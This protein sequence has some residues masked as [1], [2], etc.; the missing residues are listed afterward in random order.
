M[1]TKKVQTPL[2]PCAQDRRLDCRASRPRGSR[3]WR[4]GGTGTAV[5]AVAALLISTAAWLAL[6][7][8]GTT[9]RCWHR[10]THFE[11]SPRSVSWRSHYSSDLRYPASSPPPPPSPPPPARR[12]GSLSGTKPIAEQLMLSHILF[13][14]AGSSRLWERRKEYVRLW[15]RPEEMRGHVWLDEQVSHDDD[16][17][18]P[19]MVSEDISRFRYT[20]PTGHPSGLRIARVVVES[21]RLGL[22]DVRW[23]VLGDDDTIFNVDNLVAVLSKYDWSEMVYIGAPSES[24]SANTYFSHNMAFGGGGIAISYALADAL[25]K[26]QD[27]CLERYPKLYGSDDRL[28]ACISE[29]GVPLTRESG[30][31]Q[32]DIRGNA[33]GLLSCHPIAPFVSIH[34][35]EAVDPFYPGLNSLE[36]LKLFTKAMKLEPRSFLQ[37]SI[38]YDQAH[39]LTFSVSLGYAVQVFPNIVYPRELERSEQTYVA[40]NRISHS[41]EFDLDTRNS[42]R[43]LCNKPIL[44]FLKDIG[45]RGDATVGT[46]MQERGIDDL[47][48]RVFCFLRSPPLHNVQIIKVL[49][50][51][52]KKNWHLVPRRLCCQTN[53]IRGDTLSLFVGQCESGALN[54]VIDNL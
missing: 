21:F 35:L 53:Q 7:F 20:N 42:L 11:G 33:H 51:P 24:H 47:K 5:V 41:S 4:Q 23:F 17:L 38:C 22:P 54:S 36:S 12:N 39:R 29:I 37:R 25:S 26:I 1:V 8:S 50:Y 46:Y 48:R 27:E 44:F 28:H 19:I 3:R 14:I 18:P 30:F 45:R 32:W 9:A 40:W 49:S 2:P 6:V 13:G 52:L 43:S 10:L 15:W 16:S 31:H 34:H